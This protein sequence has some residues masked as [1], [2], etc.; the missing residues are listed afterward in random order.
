MSSPARI[1]VRICEDRVEPWGPNDF[2]LILLRSSEGEREL[3]AALRG[4]GRNASKVNTKLE[5]I[6]I[7]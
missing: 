5:V 1:P 4:V 6:R 7:Y 2:G 3:R